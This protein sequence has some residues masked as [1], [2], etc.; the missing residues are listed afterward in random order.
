MALRCAFVIAAI[1]RLDR[2]IR[3][4]ETLQQSHKAAACRYP[5]FAAATVYYLATPI[6]FSRDLL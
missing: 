4:P 5:A 3:S 6:G 2:A 1:A